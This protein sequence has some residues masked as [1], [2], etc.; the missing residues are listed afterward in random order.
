MITVEKR[1]VYFG[2]RQ[3][4]AAAPVEQGAFAGIPSPQF[5]DAGAARVPSTLTAENT[6]HDTAIPLNV[7]AKSHTDGPITAIAI[8]GDSPI[9]NVRIAV[10]GHIFSISPDRPYVGALS[11]TAKVEVMPG[12]SCPMVY[13][14]P[15]YV[16]TY[17]QYIRDIVTWDMPNVDKILTGTYPLV[18]IDLAAPRPCAKLEVYRGGVPSHLGGARRA[19][20]TAEMEW[21]LTSYLDSVQ[22]EPPAPAV[23]HLNNPAMLAIVDGR[24]RW[25]VTAKQL[26]VGAG[27]QQARISIWGVE[28]YKTTN[29]T[30]PTLQSPRADSPSFDLLMA[31]TDIPDLTTRDPLIFQYS[32]NP[33]WG[34][35]V[36]VLAAGI[37][38]RDN[39]NGS[40]AAGAT[41]HVA[42]HAWDD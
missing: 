5:L 35:F 20:Y 2:A 28:G 15:V 38:E 12:R 31:A 11:P 22:P 17:A 24:R 9:A 40:G 27:G 42:I 33:Y 6:V 18:G 41:G 25:T 39:A 7:P 26:A 3:S 19:A 21:Q 4:G 36:F 29:G 10:D 1:A 16:P 37:G 32:G 30:D 14:T 34:V 23:Y 13:R 8:A